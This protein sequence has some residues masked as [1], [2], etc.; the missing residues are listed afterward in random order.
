MLRWRDIQAVKNTKE[1]PKFTGS[2]AN[3]RRSKP[4]VSLEG[5]YTHYHEEGTI[6]MSEAP[7][8]LEDRVAYLEENIR[9]LNKASCDTARAIKGLITANQERLDDI[10]DIM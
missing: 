7:E 6:T 8:S 3:S 10:S 9:V 2:A 4:S 5:L 1:Y